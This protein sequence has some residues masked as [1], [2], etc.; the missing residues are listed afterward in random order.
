MQGSSE[1][2]VDFKYKSTDGHSKAT[3]EDVYGGSKT[4]SGLFDEAPWAV[5][6][7]MNERNMVWND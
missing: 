1:D 5:G 4:S 3:I 6:W 7:Q 2:Y